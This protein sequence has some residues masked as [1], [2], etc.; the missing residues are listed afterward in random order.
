MSEERDLVKKRGSFKGRLTAFVTFLDSLK[1]KV[2]SSCDVS[3]LQLRMGK[4]ESLYEQYDE[5]QLRLEC[6]ADDLK[7]T[8][9]AFLC[10]NCW[11]RID[12]AA[13]RSALELEPE[14]TMH[15]P[16]LEVEVDTMASA[17]AE[18][19]DPDVPHN[20]QILMPNYIRAPSTQRQCFFPACNG[21]ERLIV[22]ASLR[23]FVPRNL[24]LSHVT[25]EDI[26]RRNL[27]IPNG[28]FGGANRKPIV[29]ADGTY[30]YIEKSSNYCDGYIIDI[31]GPCPAT[32]TDSDIINSEFSDENSPCRQFFQPG[33]VFILDRGF[34]DSLVLLENCG[35]DVH[36][37]LSL[38][39]GETQLSSI[40]SSS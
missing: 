10:H 27:L 6:I 34:R 37:P 17:Q 11:R 20:N 28:L 16:S 39:E 24:G 5:V 30:I 26:S 18:D 29:I 3:E 40:A 31:L 36:V 12:R 21:T 8:R 1:D 4:M 38:E 9:T 13:S 33:D 2:L 35:Y 14:A 32:T 19:R 25:R 22:P 23:D 7:L 15:S